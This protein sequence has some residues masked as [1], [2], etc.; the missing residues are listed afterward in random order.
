[1]ENYEVYKKEFMESLRADSAIS[2][3]DTEDEFLSRTLDMLCGYDEIRIL[4]GW[5]LAI[6]VV[7][8]IE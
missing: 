4:R 1:M 2:G 6:S 3:S 7:P 8:E 5:V